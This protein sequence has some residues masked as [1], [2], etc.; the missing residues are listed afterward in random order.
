MAESVLAQFGWVDD[1]ALR[2]PSAQMRCA[3]EMAITLLRRE[4]SGSASSR[5]PPSCMRALPT[6][7][8]GKC[9]CCICSHH[10]HRPWNLILR[11]DRDRS[12]TSIHCFLQSMEED[13]TRNRL[14]Y[15]SLQTGVLM[16]LPDMGAESP[17][18]PPSLIST[19]DDF[20]RE[21]TSS[22]IRIVVEAKGS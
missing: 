3:R 11:R 5:P 1:R 17:I 4:S 15:R 22:T 8:V 12:N 16:D 20:V 14:R 9:L 2:D 21:R 13:S 10:P 18:G 7:V 19:D 6:H